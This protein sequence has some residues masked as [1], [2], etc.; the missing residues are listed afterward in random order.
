MANHA[1]RSG[2]II[3][4]KTPIADLLGIAAPARKAHIAFRNSANEIVAAILY[5]P[6]D[7]ASRTSE[8][9]YRLMSSFGESNPCFSPRRGNPKPAFER[10]FGVRLDEVTVEIEPVIGT[11]TSAIERELRSRLEKIRH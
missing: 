1:N 8:G 2:E 10:R 9:A 7:E 5:M 11:N 4:S 6:R 3:T